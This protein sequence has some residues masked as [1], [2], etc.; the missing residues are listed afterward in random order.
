MAPSLDN[1]TVFLDRDGTLN[2]DSGYITSPDE[3]ILF[4]GVVPAIAR[5]NRSGSR[6]VLVTN[7]SGIARGLMTVEDLQVIHRKLEDEL[8]GGGG[9]LDG[10]YFCSHHPD[11]ACQ[12]RKPNAGL[13][14]Q[15]AKELGLNVS[16]SYFIGDK[17]VDMELANAVGSIAVLVMTSEYSQDAAQAMEKNQI[18]VAFVASK[19]GEAANWILEDASSRSWR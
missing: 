18:Q 13:I 7:Q 3:L 5:L 15:A 4:P 19:F 16:R 6:V 12:C 10:I 2:Y 17:V 1:L 14:R 8:R 9:W 11:D